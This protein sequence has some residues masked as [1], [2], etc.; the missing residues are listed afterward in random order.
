MDK[1]IKNY[2]QWMSKKSVINNKGVIRS[3]REGDVWWGAIGENVGVEIDGKSKRYSRPIVILKKH[4]R[5]L[6]MAVPLTSKQH[7]GTWYVPFIFQNKHQ[8]AVLVQTKPMDVT[9]LYERIGKLSNADYQRIKEA[10]L[11]LLS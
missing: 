9:R 5:L 7:N 10:Y 6:F 3:F 11:K 1:L 4:S 2:K 8:T